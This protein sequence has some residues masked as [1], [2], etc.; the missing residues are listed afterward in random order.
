MTLLLDQLGWQGKGLPT[1]QED[2]GSRGE[3][4]GLGRRPCT[5]AAE[6]LGASGLHL[7]EE[8]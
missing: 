2:G 1:P 4:S 5:P 6:L 3:S 7:P 8:V